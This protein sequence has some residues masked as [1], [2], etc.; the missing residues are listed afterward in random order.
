MRVRRRYTLREMFGLE[1]RAECA[2]M[3]RKFRMNA[4]EERNVSLHCSYLIF[5]SAGALLPVD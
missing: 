3:K 2:P 1:L 4:I 5:G